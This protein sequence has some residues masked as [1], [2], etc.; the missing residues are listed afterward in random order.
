MGFLSNLFG[1]PD[2]LATVT[3]EADPLLVVDSEGNRGFMGR[4][5]VEFTPDSKAGQ[6]GTAAAALD[7]PV[8]LHMQVERR[9]DVEASPDPY[10]RTRGG[11][12][13]LGAD[14]AGN[15]VSWHLSRAADDYILVHPEE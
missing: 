7:T 10:T 6:T 15:P 13:F 14:L 4:T 2:P 1:K 9:I 3:F 11:L 5:Q 8:P 12:T